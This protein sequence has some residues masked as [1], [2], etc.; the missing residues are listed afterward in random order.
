[1][2]LRRQGAKRS[3]PNHDLSHRRRR[4]DLDLLEGRCVLSGGITVIRALLPPAIVL[5]IG[6]G[7]AFPR[8]EMPHASMAV[9]ASRGFAFWPERPA[10]FH[11]DPGFWH[12]PGFG[13]THILA[14]F[15][16]GTPASSIS[17]A[18]E[19]AH[20]ALPLFA[21]PQVSLP[22]TGSPD[23]SMPRMFQ[24]ANP[25]F[26]IPHDHAPQL[27]PPSGTIAENFDAS[28]RDPEG[29]ISQNLNQV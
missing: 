19:V 17:P 23:P 20:P 21:V 16:Q 2:R 25:D 22:M 3:M 18:D 26:E 24:K 1:M 6:P 14:E 9:P 7:T 28:A 27:R 8:P 5:G 15:F 12:G 11:E 13:G 10:G 29:V 4:P